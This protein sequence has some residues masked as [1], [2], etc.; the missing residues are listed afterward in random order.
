[1]ARGVQP[2]AKGR[3]SLRISVGVAPPRT[4][5]RMNDYT[6]KRIDVIVHVVAAITPPTTFGRRSA[7][8]MRTA[9]CGADDSS[10]NRDRIPTFR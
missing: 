2:P 1:M 8:I 3:R 4:G 9:T 7:E 6:L 5:L 10:L